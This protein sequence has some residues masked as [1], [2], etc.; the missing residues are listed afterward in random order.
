MLDTTDI[1]KLK[2]IFTTKKDAKKFATIE[3]QKEIISGIHTIIEMIGGE[4]DKNKE[5]DEI[6]NRH[7]IQLNKLKNKVFS[8]N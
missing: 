1:K 4:N 2:K 3:G 6:L 8:T 7:E 5:Q